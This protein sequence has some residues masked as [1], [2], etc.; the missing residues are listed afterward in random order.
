MVNVT[1][2]SSLVSDGN[3]IILSFLAPDGK[4]RRYKGTVTHSIAARHDL[5]SDHMNK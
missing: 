3:V 1:T 5:A 4:C 2:L